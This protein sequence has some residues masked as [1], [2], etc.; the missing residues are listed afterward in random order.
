MACLKCADIDVN[1][2]QNAALITG[3]AA[4]LSLPQKLWQLGDVR[5][6]PSRL[7]ARLCRMYAE[8]GCKRQSRRDWDHRRLCL[9]SVKLVQ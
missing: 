1:Q 8:R 3:R 7:I 4:P 6:D 5:C 2:E 9:G